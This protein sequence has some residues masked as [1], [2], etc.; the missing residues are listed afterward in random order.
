MRKITLFIITLCMGLFTFGYAAPININTA[1]ATEIAVNLS[2]IGPAKADAII[3][4]REKHG[5][6]E[7]IYDLL[8]VKGIGEKTVELNRENIL[9]G[10]TPE[11]KTAPVVTSSQAKTDTTT[12]VDMTEAHQSPSPQS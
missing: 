9:I 6:F 10:I 1:N 3:D 7:S 11:T 4:Y 2:N 5:P 8:K 12:E